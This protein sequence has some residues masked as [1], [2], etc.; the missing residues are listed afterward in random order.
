MSWPTVAMIETCGK[1][2]VEAPYWR[3]IVIAEAKVLD[4][5]RV[6]IPAEVLAAIGAEPGAT[7]TFRRIGPG[8]LEI[9]AVD[10][11]TLS[12]ALERFRVEGPFDEA[13][14]R[15]EWQDEAAKDVVGR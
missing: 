3:R 2:R 12:E 5:G 4:D 8:T 1:G 14:L 10:E 13:K 6:A 9:K 15:E 7:V 11:L